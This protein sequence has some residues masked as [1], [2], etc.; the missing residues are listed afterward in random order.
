MGG[1]ARF[2]LHRHQDITGASGTG[3]VAVGVIFEDG[4]AVTH[5]LTDTRSTVVWHTA[6]PDEARA[7][8]QRIHGHG[9]HTEIRWLD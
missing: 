1:A 6:T 7:A 9:G 5:W 8:I 2:E 3:R 4:V